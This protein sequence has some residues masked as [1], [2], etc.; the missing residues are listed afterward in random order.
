MPHFEWLAL[1]RRGSSASDSAWVRAL[2]G[3][4]LGAILVLVVLMVID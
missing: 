3:V 4:A 2:L 1:A